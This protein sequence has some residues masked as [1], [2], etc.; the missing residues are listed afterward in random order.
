MEGGGEEG[1]DEKPRRSVGGSNSRRKEG[2]A[3]LLRL[4][5]RGVK[6]FPP[7]LPPS[8]LAYERNHGLRKKGGKERER[9]GEG[10]GGGGGGSGGGGGGG[11][12]HHQRRK[13]PSPS[14]PAPKSYKLT[15]SED[16]TEMLSCPLPPPFPSLPR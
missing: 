8:P 9:D 6:S 10:G 7:S 13:P 16:K 12:G 5:F 11:G 15:L 14:F 4:L 2:V 3:A 1:V